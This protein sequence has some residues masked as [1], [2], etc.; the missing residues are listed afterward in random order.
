MPQ[1]VTLDVPAELIKDPRSWTVE[2]ISIWLQWLGIG[3]HVESFAARGVDGELLLQLSAD[4][5][6]AELGVHDVAQQR[7]LDS[8]VEP[9]RCFHHGALDATLALHA[10]EGPVAGQIFFVGA[11]VTGGRHNASNNIVLSENYVSRRH[12]QILR[13]RVGQY[14]LQDVGSTTGTFLMIREELPLEDQMIIQL[15]TTEITAHIDG[16]RC[17]LL[18]T[19]G[20]DKDISVTVPPVG[21]FIGREGGN[22][23]CIRDPQISSFHCE[24]R[25]SREGFL[26][27]DKYS[28]NR[29]W[30]RLAPDGQPSKRYLLRIGDL[31]KVGST[32]FHVVEP[33]SAEPEEDGVALGVEEHRLEH[34]HFPA[35]P[36]SD[37]ELSDPDAPEL[38]VAHAAAPELLAP[39]LAS[40]LRWEPFLDTD[41]RPMLPPDEYARRLTEARRIMVEGS[42][43]RA[44]GTANELHG[45]QDARIFEE[46]ELSS[47]Q[48][49]MRNS[50]AQT[51]YTLQQ[52]RGERRDEDLC[53]ICYDND[54]DVVLY[55]CGHFMLCRWCAQMVSDCPVC[56]LVITDVIRTYKA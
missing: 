47:L 34:T 16:T 19:E 23:L 27:D 33:A 26:L 31:F 20:P 4:A 46:R 56:R 51:A 50:R 11:G 2:D 17:T 40:H 35:S 22:G 49:R 54:I 28:T 12:F 10:I 9:L 15:G 13:D 42:A 30:L 53:K 6:W 1:A 52:K 41:A 14:L 36:R 38:H 43:R 3:E 45:S 25:P 32:L 29:T 48:Q 55:P 7:V 8:A 24:V 39:G 5:N 37:S 21:V 44:A 18:V